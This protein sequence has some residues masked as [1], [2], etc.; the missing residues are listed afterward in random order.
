MYKVGRLSVL[1]EFSSTPSGR[2]SPVSRRMYLLDSSIKP[3][4]TANDSKSP[5]KCSAGM[6]SE[7]SSVDSSS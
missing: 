5:P 4:L 1:T 6:I 3:S 7:S 2:T